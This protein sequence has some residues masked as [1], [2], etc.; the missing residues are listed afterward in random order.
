MQLARQSSHQIRVRGVV[1]AF[2]GHAHNRKCQVSKL[3][4]PDFFDDD[5]VSGS[6]ASSIHCRGRSRGLRD[7]REDIFSL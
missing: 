5:G 3:P 4:A 7:L 2:H 6:V 1:P